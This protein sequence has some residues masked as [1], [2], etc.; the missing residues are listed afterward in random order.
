MPVSRR[1]L[2]QLLS[3]GTVLVS[4]G[5]L[6]GSLPSGAP[7][8]TFPQGVA[9]GDPQPDGVMLWTRAEPRELTGSSVPL[10]L[11]LSRTADFAQLAL[12]TRLLAEADKDFT[13]RIYVDQLQADSRYFYRFLGAGGATSPVGRTR[14]APVPGQDREVRLAFASC[15]SYEQGFYGNWARMLANDQALPEE[16]QL[17][18]VLHLGDFIYERSWPRLADGRPVPRPLP[19]FPD[20][21]HSDENSWAVSLADYRH[22]YKTYLSDPHLQ[23][24]RAR[25]PFICTWDDHEFSNDNFGYHS[26]YGGQHRAESE[27]KVAAN[28]AWFEFI[29][30]V[31][32]ELGDQPAH[33][34]RDPGAQASPEQAVDS[35]HI[36]RRLQWG[37]NLDIVLTDSR[38]YRTPPCL[39]PG[40][41]NSLGL[42]VE[43]VQ[44]VEIADAG[45]AYN[46]G[47]P[48][49]FL[50]YGDGKTQ[51][52]GWRRPPGSL[53]GEPQR[54][55]FL[56]Q[57]SSSNARWKLWGNAL[58]LIPMRIDLD[59]LPFTDY[60]HSIFHLDAWAG[61][62][63]EQSLLMRHLEQAAVTGVVS[64][65]GDHHMHGAGTV[66]HDAGDADANPVAVDFSVAGIS[67]TP[68][69]MELFKVSGESH[70]DFAALV[71][72]DEQGEIVPV[73]NMTMLDG[74]LAS[75][76]YGQTGIKGAARWLGPNSANPGLSYMDSTANGYGLAHFSADKLQ[77]DMV[78]LNSV[79]NAFTEPPE[80][81]YIASFE[82]P[83]WQPGAPPRLAGP[84]L[85]G[86]APFPFEP[87]S[88]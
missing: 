36:Y 32:D 12:D 68:M 41:A 39:P 24:A 84:R 53:L 8:P 14:T 11:Q 50:P 10:Q 16:E 30:A 61:F 52:P 69:F 29:P 59:S 35:L 37:K 63:H 34:F 74:A 25:W 49:Q 80:I 31:L 79:G 87:D 4:A 85:R 75:L 3:S 65:S 44:L 6:G 72:S 27:R 81:D 88:V 77:V 47:E 1:N 78:T 40:L 76:A 38:S 33:D 20:G 45:D 71:Y 62:P 86:G 55:W 18:F 83:L 51:N 13:L 23:A 66:K 5:T 82:L 67:S 58:P 42:P 60:E 7:R 57:M 21:E 26:T 2:L 28:R 70:P 22:L 15:Q 48:P 19:P 64:F 9:S 54:Q 46:G 56:E 73:W 43:S 17:D